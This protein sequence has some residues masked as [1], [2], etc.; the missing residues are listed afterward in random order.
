MKNTYE[1][2]MVLIVDKATIVMGL[3]LV[4]QFDFT[5]CQLYVLF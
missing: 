3:N 2:Q 4:I 5:L 1:F